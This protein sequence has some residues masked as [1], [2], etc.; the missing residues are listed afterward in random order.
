MPLFSVFLFQPALQLSGSQ[1]EKKQDDQK[2]EQGAAHDQQ[3]ASKQ[4]VSDW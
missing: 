1:G 2:E 3:T 4:F